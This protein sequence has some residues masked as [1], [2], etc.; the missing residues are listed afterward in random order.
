[1]S[2][3]LADTELGR[4]QQLYLRDGLRCVYNS[5]RSFHQ[6]SLWQTRR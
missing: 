3:E 2:F 6:L 5:T 1:M 4:G